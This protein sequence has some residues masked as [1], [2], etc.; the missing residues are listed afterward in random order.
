M[1]SWTS[2]PGNVAATHRPDRLRMATIR[3]EQALAMDAHSIHWWDLL[4]F[5]MLEALLHGN[6]L[7]SSCLMVSMFKVLTH[8][9]KDGTCFT[10][11]IKW[12]SMYLQPH[13]RQRGG[14]HFLTP[15]N[16]GLR[17]CWATRTDYQN[18]L[19]IQMILDKLW[20]CN[21]YRQ[22]QNSAKICITGTS[23][24]FANVVKRSCGVIQL[25][26]H[27]L[28]MDV[29]KFIIRLGTPCSQITSFQ[30][31]PKGC[32]LRFAF[33]ALPTIPGMAGK[34]LVTSCDITPREK[35]NFKQVSRA[36]IPCQ[37]QQCPCAFFW[38]K[39]LGGERTG[40]QHFFKPTKSRKSWGFSQLFHR[41]VGLQW[42]LNI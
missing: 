20:K 21:K 18:L 19:E 28:P 8:V 34:M 15:P 13:V 17:S 1:W 30:G 26:Y 12:F 22:P 25:A 5:H 27:E 14:H 24:L 23:I 42:V 31:F 29:Q 9:L 37:K 38:S 40:A 7:R 2:L 36:S 3:A 4:R 16:R 32:W 41:K 39:C 11:C 6:L 35:K 10:A 33:E